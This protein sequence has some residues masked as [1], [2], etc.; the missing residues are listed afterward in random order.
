MYQ[1]KYQCASATCNL[2]QAA[3]VRGAVTLTGY[4]Q[5]VSTSDT[6]HPL[7]ILALPT[8]YS[9]LPHPPTTHPGPA[10]HLAFPQ[11]HLVHEHQASLSG[12]TWTRELAGKTEGGAGVGKQAAIETNYI[13]P[14]LQ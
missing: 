2:L 7:L 12:V 6:A 3:S 9:S 10:T 8:H 13:F 11:G 4:S 14:Y 5:V 1:L